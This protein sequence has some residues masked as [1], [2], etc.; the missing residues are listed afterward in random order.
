MFFTLIIFAFQ[1]S[2]TVFVCSA[3]AALTSYVSSA[4]VLV[5][6]NDWGMLIVA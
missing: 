4:Q 2:L 1:I 5:T 3:F 6:A